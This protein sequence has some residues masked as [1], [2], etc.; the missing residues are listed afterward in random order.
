[1]E[2][3]SCENCLK[4]HILFNIY[5]HGSL[6]DKNE[7]YYNPKRKRTYIYYIDKNALLKYLEKLI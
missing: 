3:N 1:M 5:N 4:L 6:L 2:T 7:N